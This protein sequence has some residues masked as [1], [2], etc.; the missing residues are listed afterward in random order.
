[1]RHQY[2]LSC[3]SRSAYLYEDLAT[4]TAGTEVN[5]TCA[6]WAKTTARS[7]KVAMRKRVILIVGCEMNGRKSKIS[8]VFEMA[9]SCYTFRVTYLVTD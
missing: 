3:C 8:N 5:A 1:M 9:D 7:D 2:G 6:P 4:T